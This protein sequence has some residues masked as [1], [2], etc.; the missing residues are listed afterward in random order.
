MRERRQRYNNAASLNGYKGIYAELNTDTGE[1]TIEL[2]DD[3]EK[4]D[5]AFSTTC[6]LR[7]NRKGVYLIRF[8]IDEHPETGK[9]EEFQ[10]HVIRKK[11]GQLRMFIY[12]QYGVATLTKNSISIHSEGNGEFFN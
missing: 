5:L 3:D 9:K 11:Y 12:P 10:A 8:S 2:Y 6:K 1:L 7:S 4:T